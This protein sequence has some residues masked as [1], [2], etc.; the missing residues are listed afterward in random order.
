MMMTETG[1]AEAEKRHSFM[2]IFLR[3]FFE[4]QG[5]PEWIDY[6]EKFEKDN[7]KAE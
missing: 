3:H 7:C 1:R 2:L 4:E 5:C 6:L